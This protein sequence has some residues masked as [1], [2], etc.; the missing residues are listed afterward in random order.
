MPSQRFSIITLAYLIILQRFLPYWFVF[1]QCILPPNFKSIRSQIRKL[2][3]V[4][5]PWETHLTQNLNFK[6]GLK[7]IFL[8]NQTLLTYFYKQ[9]NYISLFINQ[10][11]KGKDWVQFVFKFH[12]IIMLSRHF[13]NH[14]YEITLKQLFRT[15]Y[16]IAFLEKY[17][18]TIQR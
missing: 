7:A 5:L 15:L 11:K 1:W 10:L 14:T 18:I 13:R 2:L 17:H 3:N 12:L 8:A 6:N 9:W 16:R 4:K